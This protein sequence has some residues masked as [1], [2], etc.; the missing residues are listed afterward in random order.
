MPDIGEHVEFDENAA[1]SVYVE[2]DMERLIRMR[3]L[4]K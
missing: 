2:N 4:F 1:A 3:K